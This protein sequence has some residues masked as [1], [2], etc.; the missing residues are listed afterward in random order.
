MR[1]EVTLFLQYEAGDWR[2]ASSRLT[3]VAVF[4]F[5]SIRF[6]VLFKYMKTE[7]R[8]HMTEKSLTET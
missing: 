2:V 5:Y 3:G 7:N 6:L 4:L 1:G 8:P